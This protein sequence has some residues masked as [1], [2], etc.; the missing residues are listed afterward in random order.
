M[1]RTDLEARIRRLEDIEEIR[2]LR[3]RYCQYLDD[4]RWSELA[5]L[6]TADGAFVGLST[7]RGRDELRT[8]FAELQSGPLQAWWHFS[9]NETITVDGDEARG[10]TWLD[11]PCVVDGEAHIAAG[12]YQDDVVRDSDGQWRFRER[13]VTFFFWGPLASGW[14]PGRIEWRPAAGALDQRYRGE[15]SAR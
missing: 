1:S 8:F 5:E 13:K 2:Q 6:F 4:G 12:R 9:S 3:A 15:G 14:A 7:A 10:E 11:Q